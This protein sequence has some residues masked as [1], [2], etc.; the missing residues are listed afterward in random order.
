MAEQVDVWAGNGLKTFGETHHAWLKCSRKRC[1]RYRAWC[2]A[3]W[4]PSTSF[5]SS[6][7]L[8]LMIPTLYKLAGELTLFVL[9]VAAGTVATDMHS[10]FLAII[11]TGSGSAPNGYSG[12]CAANVQEAQDFALYFA[13]CDAEKSRLYSFLYGFQHLTKSIKLS[14]WPMT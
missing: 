11:P 9:H 2:F 7:G 14:R 8:L 4:C 5:T 13:H 1:Y 6:Q 10:L 3:N 12:C